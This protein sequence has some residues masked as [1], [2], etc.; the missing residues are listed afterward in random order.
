MDFAEHLFTQVN[1]VAYLV[2]CIYV[3]C[4]QSQVYH[5][6]MMVPDEHRDMM[7]PDEHRDMMV[8]DEHR[9]M[10]VPD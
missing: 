6:D 5:R 4:Q 1:N 3:I 7:V 10:M 9:D 2:T 8:P